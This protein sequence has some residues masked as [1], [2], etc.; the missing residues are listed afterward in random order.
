MQLKL[1][2]DRFVKTMESQAEI[3]GTE[4]GGLH[5]LAL[6]DADGAVRDWFV[7]QLEELGLTV[8]IDEFGNVFGRRSGTDPDGTPVLVGSHLDSQPNGGIYDG[9]LGVVAGLELL[10]TLDDE[11]IE[12]AHPIEIVNWTNEEGSRFQPGLQ[13]SGVWS[14]EFDLETEYDRTDQNGD[15]L[16]DELK[17]IGYQGDAAAE[18]TETY[19]AYFELHIEQG[20]YLEE[21][22][23]DVG[24]VSGI[25]G[26]SWGEVTFTGQAN[27]AGSTPMHLRSDAAVP[28]AEFLTSV[29]RLPGSIGERTVGTVGSIEVEPDSINVIPASA[30]VT[31]D[32]RDPSDEVLDRAI[33]RL[34]QEAAAAAS[35][36]GVDHEVNEAARTS[37]VAFDDRC[38]SAVQRAADRLGYDSMQLRSGGNH[39]ASHVN[40][41]CDAGMVFAVS[42]D[43]K[44]HTSAEFTSWEDCYRAA[45]TLAT[46][47]VST[48]IGGNDRSADPIDR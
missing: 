39:D 1:D 3:G 44:S 45:N 31:W 27:H 35:R 12:T 11:G 21:T 8:R 40:A 13:G 48:A 23:N 6:S 37:S 47:V 30:S 9:P 28:A 4:D 24:V 16:V 32:I 26:L 41:V 25:V 19:E 42:E 46:A 43:G 34:T 14:G 15:R 2:R 22:G 18:P 7:D 36:E 10:R 17:R 33:E 29:R 20:P 38:V 5:R